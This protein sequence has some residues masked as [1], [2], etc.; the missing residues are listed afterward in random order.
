[1]MILQRKAESGLRGPSC[2][3][4]NFSRRFRLFLGH[5]QKNGSRIFRN[6]NGKPNMRAK[7]RMGIA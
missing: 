3:I 5:Q 1:M 2:G 4:R 6:H 7:N